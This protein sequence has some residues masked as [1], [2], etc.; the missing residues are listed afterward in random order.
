MDHHTYSILYSLHSRLT[1]LETHTKKLN[2]LTVKL[3]Y[4]PDHLQLIGNE[5]DGLVFKVISSKGGSTPIAIK[6]IRKEIAT[7]D[8]VSHSCLVKYINY[9]MVDVLLYLEKLN[10]RHRDLESVN[11]KVQMPAMRL[12]VFDFARADLPDVDGLEPTQC[13]NKI[14][15]EAYD[16]MMKGKGTDL[17]R[18]SLEHYKGVRH[19]YKVPMTTSSLYTPIT[20]ENEYTDFTM[21]EILASSQN[22]LWKSDVQK[23]LHAHSLDVVEQYQHLLNLFHSNIWSFPER[24][25]ST[26]QNVLDPNKYH[27]AL[28]I[29]IKKVGLWSSSIWQGNSKDYDTFIRREKGT[30][31][32][33]NV[34]L[35]ESLSLMLVCAPR[36]TDH[37]H[38][39]RTCRY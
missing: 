34:S 8:L 22:R 29:A 26:L 4:T 5:D 31:N 24:K 23:L 14:I 7:I 35:S 12:V 39:G 28:N 38:H 25:Q 16:K 11:V 33:I 19:A 18:A 20:K 2:T 1:R 17:Q 37:V 36:H 9:Q 3:S 15:A 27:I 30:Y 6:T 13:P 21:M 10:I 32:V